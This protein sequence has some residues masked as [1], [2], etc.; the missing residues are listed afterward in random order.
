MDDVPFKEVAKRLQVNDS[1]VPRL[2]NKYGSRLGIAVK[3]GQSN[4]TNRKW[5]HFLSREDA[6]KLVAFYEAQRGTSE[7]K[8]DD[9]IFLQQFGV[10]YII[11][12]V[13]EALPNR[14]KIGYT[15]NLENRLATHQCAAPTA[16]VIASWPCKRSWDYAAMDS[17]T[18]EECEWVLNEVFEGDPQE[19][20]RRG[21]EFFALMPKPDGERRLSEHSPLQKG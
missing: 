17:V 11:Q 2:I 7:P 20:V 21:K 18:R 3:K 16:R 15:D 14:V 9:D 5:S 12:L 10:F 6:D 8:E 4:T 1:T 19:F 13:P